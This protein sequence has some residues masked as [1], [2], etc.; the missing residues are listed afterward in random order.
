MSDAHDD[1]ASGNRVPDPVPASGIGVGDNVPTSSETVVSD[2]VTPPVPR[3]H[4]ENEHP[5]RHRV[6]SLS[7]D[8]LTQN[9]AREAILEAKRTVSAVHEDVI[10]QQK[11]L[12]AKIEALMRATEHPS[13]IYFSASEEEN[14]DIV[15]PSKGKSI[16]PRNWG[17]LDLPENETNPETQKVSSKDTAVQLLVDLLLRRML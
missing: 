17:G 3:I 14:D 2:S 5:V 9:S 12:D 6:C 10:E 11:Q 8:S 16:D 15:G 7:L 1:T 4:F 13:S